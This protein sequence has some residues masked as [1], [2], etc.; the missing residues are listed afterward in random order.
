MLPGLRIRGAQFCRPLPHGPW[1]P[2]PLVFQFPP[3]GRE[4]VNTPEAFA[5]RLDRFLSG[6]PQG[7]AYAVEVRDSRLLSEAYVAALRRT[8]VQ[9]CISVHPRMHAAARQA[10]LVES[11]GLASLVIRWN[12]HA[13]LAYEQARTRYQPCDRLLDPDSESR[14]AIA[15]ACVR[16]LAAGRTVY[17]TANNKAEGCA[18]LTLIELAREIA[19]HAPAG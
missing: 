4:I 1:S 9:H 18:P 10:R 2:G 12:L 17:V 5:A 8:A 16:A 19:L 6:L 11:L 15:G 13:G 7:P 14:S 3:Q